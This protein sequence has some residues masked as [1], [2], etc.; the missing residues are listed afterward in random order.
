MPNP[1]QN[2]LP[3]TR[4]SLAYGQRVRVRPPHPDAGATGLVLNAYLYANGTEIVS[5]LRKG[6]LCVVAGRGVSSAT[7]L[8]LASWT[9]HGAVAS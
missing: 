3:P 7:L 4:F 2:P 1:L 5:W 6:H 9:D 8:K